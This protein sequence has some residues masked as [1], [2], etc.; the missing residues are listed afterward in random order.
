MQGPED[1]DARGEGGESIAR[2]GRRIA[3]LAWLMLQCWRRT[4]GAARRGHLVQRPFP[5]RET[6]MK[7]IVDL[8]VIP[9][10]ADSSLSKYVAVCE[11]ILHEAGLKVHLHAYGT[12]IEGEWDAVFAAVKRC[13]EALHD[14]GVPR[15][16]TTLKVGTRTDREQTMEDKVNSVKRLMGDGGE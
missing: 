7:A 13:H 14:M 10:G 8:C 11:K 4:H 1:F 5:A 3:G 16:H 9:L 2:A 15:I 6:A 12:N